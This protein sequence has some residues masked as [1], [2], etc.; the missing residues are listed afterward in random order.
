[1]YCDK[2]ANFDTNTHKPELYLSSLAAF[3]KKSILNKKQPN[4]NKYKT[5][6]CVV[7]VP[8]FAS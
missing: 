2:V 3:F 5:G 8:K 4:D 6:L 7:F 1:M